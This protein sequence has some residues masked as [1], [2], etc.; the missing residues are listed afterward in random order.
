MA[1]I[2]AKAGYPIVKKSA[3]AKIWVLNS[4]TVKTPSETQ[5]SNLLE[6]GR[7]LGKYVVMAGCVSQLNIADACKAANMCSTDCFMQAAPDEPWL[8]N[9]SIV[10]VKQIDRILEVV[11]ETLKGN[12]VRLLSRKRPDAGLSLPKMRKNDLVEVLAINTGCLNHCTYCKT[13]M[14]R[15]DLKSYP[16]EEL[17]EQV[18]NLSGMTS[19]FFVFW[20]TP[21]FCER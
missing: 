17:V 8:K 9:V 7:K 1:G 13:K 2:L 14:A 10:G 16:L 15:G 11:E 5:A 21:E 6:E 20:S 18:S 12:T 4:C 3:D 19:T